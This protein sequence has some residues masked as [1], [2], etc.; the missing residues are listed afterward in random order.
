MANWN[1]ILSRGD[2]EDRRSN[3]PAIVGGLSLTGVAIVIAFNLLT[4]GS[5]TDILNQLQ[6]IPVEQKQNIDTSQFEGADNYEVFAS[7]VLGS[8][9]DMWASIFKQK[10]EVYTPP[11]LVLFR[12]ATES[13]C[14]T[15]T[16]DVGPHYCP[17][18]N[19]IYLDETF[20]DELTNRF[21][22]KGGDVAEAYVIAH[23][24]GHHAQNELGIMDEMQNGDENE[25]SVKLELQADCFAGLWAHSIRDS[26]VFQ[27]G[28]IEEAIDAAAAV[29]DDRIQEKV[30]GQVNP[31]TWTH[32]SSAQRVSWFNRGYDSGTLDACN[33][34]K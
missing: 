9:N 18:D 4:G 3:A 5:A 25:M 33:T 22:A 7:T 28:E 16:S 24:V 30:T 21:G 31:E 12:T 29:G 32:G 14:G 11:K 8:D 23:E 19:T 20:F 1:K 27:P 15:A 10:N 2:V 34:F 17:A 13:G 26:D 6:S